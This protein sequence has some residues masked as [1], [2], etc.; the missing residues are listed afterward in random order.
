[1]TLSPLATG[2]VVGLGFL[3]NLAV[4]A[5]AIISEPVDEGDRR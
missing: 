4:I 5:W 3:L 1:M 2:A